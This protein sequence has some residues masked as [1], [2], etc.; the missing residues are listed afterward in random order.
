MYLGVKDTSIIT[1]L[2]WYCLQSFWK[3]FS[4]FKPDYFS[5]FLFNFGNHFVL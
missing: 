3:G 4:W 2:G 5:A 1:E